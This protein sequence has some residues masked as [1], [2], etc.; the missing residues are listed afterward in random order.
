MSVVAF[1]GLTAGDGARQEATVISSE[2]VPRRNEVAR[3]NS[4]VR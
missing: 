4:S 3:E 2:L 1:R